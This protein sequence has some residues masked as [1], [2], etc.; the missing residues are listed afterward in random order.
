MCGGGPHWVGGAVGGTPIDDWLPPA[1]P[2]PPRAK[3]GGGLDKSGIAP[4][5]FI[6]GGGPLNG[7]IVACSPGTIGGG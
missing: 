6:K 4:D 1:G 5:G 7:G 2:L 3:P